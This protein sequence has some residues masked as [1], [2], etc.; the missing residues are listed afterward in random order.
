MT[1]KASSVVSQRQA[2]AQFAS[3]W[4]HCAVFDSLQTLLDS[5]EVD[6]VF[7]GVPPAF[8]GCFEFPLELQCLKAGAHVFVEKPLGNASVETA[9]KYAEAVEA[10]RLQR[11]LLV[12]SGTIICLDHHDHITTRSPSCVSCRIQC[13]VYVP[14]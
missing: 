7:I 8:H 3:Q 1:S 2:N 9:R 11:G 5:V 10:E 6:A 13:R 14:P 12:R 4:S